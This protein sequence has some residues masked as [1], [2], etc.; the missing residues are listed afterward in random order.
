[1]PIE[2]SPLAKVFELRPAA[3]LA[4]RAA[5]RPANAVVPRP[6]TAANKVLVIGVS[7][8]RSLGFVIGEHMR[9]AG[10]DTVLTTRRADKLLEVARGHDIRVLDYP[11]SLDSIDDLDDVTG[12]VFCLA[13][14]DVG[15]RGRGLLGVSEQNFL[16]TLNT[17]C[18]AFIS[19]VREVQQ[20][21]PGLKSIVALSFLGGEQIV[22]GYEVLGIAKAALEHSVRALAAELGPE[23][24]RVNAVSAGSVPT[25]SSRVLPDF[26]RVH[27]VLA[28][29]AFL[30]RN[31]TSD[32]IASAT[33][34]LLSDASSGLTGEIMQVNAGIR[35]AVL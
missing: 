25:A 8:R 29:R 4:N 16:Q 11:S 26:R 22:P 20:R 23:G 15:E 34:F 14:T 30:R 32:E 21:N 5:S 17:S 33:A 3:R 31:V 12:M 35:H 9:E 6:E 13:K 18:Y 28:R 19:L 1:M 2:K 10:W 27:E 7:S 24:I